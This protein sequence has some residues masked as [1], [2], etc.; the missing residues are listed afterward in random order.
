MAVSVVLMKK[1]KSL[2]VTPSWIHVAWEFECDRIL[3]SYMGQLRRK[4]S[5]SFD[6]E[7]LSA[8]FA[9]LLERQAT[10]LDGE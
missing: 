4:S 5:Y 7:I 8:H 2:K 9:T 3:I 1:C 10:K 6:L